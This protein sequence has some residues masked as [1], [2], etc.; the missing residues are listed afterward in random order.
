[1]D[2]SNACFHAKLSSRSDVKSASSASTACEHNNG[3]A[4]SQCQQGGAGS[5]VARYVRRSSKKLQGGES[6]YH[7]ERIKLLSLHLADSD[8]PNGVDTFFRCGCFSNTTTAAN[9]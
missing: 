5:G 1:M 6:S 4:V 8:G 9:V 2:L 3:Y 7:D